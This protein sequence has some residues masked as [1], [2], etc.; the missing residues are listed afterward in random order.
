MSAIC[1]GCHQEVDR[2]SGAGFCSSGICSIMEQGYLLGLQD[3]NRHMAEQARLA[4]RIRPIRAE[5]VRADAKREPKGEVTEL[6]V[7]N[8]WP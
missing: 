8:A 6:R 5:A 2:V 1:K 3:V 4:Q 7:V